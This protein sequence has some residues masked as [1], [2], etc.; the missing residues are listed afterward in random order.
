V[1]LTGPV[2]GNLERTALT[3]HTAGKLHLLDRV[4]HVLTA[5]ARADD[6]ANPD[7]AESCDPRASS[8]CAWAGKQIG[9]SVVEIA[10][11]RQTASAVMRGLV[12]LRRNAMTTTMAPGR[13][14][15]RTETSH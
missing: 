13:R 2:D 12:E 3:G 1:S 7:P 9:G 8:G 11:D 4:R 6:P 5:A 14:T 15:A 10:P